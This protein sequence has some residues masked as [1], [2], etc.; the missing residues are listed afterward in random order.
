MPKCQAPLSNMCQP[1]MGYMSDIP[2]A[3]RNIPWLGPG[4]PHSKHPNQDIGSNQMAGGRAI[5]T[6]VQ[7]Q[8]GLSQEDLGPP[9][10]GSGQ[11]GPPKPRP[12]K[13]GPDFPWPESGVSGTQPGVFGG[14]QRV[15][16]TSELTYFSMSVKMGLFVSPDPTR[17]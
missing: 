6:P 15:F 4:Q 16:K 17:I 11:W 5:D 1:K 3:G 7:E 13:F 12:G 10:P 2:P 14:R 9:G 8:S